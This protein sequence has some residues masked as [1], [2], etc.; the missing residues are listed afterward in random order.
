MGLLHPARDV[1]IR[2]AYDLLISSASSPSART[3]CA[4]GRWPRVHRLISAGKIHSDIQRGF[5]APKTI[6]YDDFVRLFRTAARTKG[7]A[8]RRQEYKV[9]D[10]EICTSTSAFDGAPIPRERG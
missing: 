6:H 8:T 10:G 1:F 2:S 4:P 3:R 7:T 5:I 9:R